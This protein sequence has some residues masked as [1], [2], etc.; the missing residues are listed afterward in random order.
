MYPIC[1][2]PQSK[3]SLA[4][5]PEHVVINLDKTVI[6]INE[7]SNLREHL[8]ILYGPQK[9]EVVLDRLIQIIQRFVADNPSFNRAND[10]K[11]E[12][13]TRVTEKDAILIA[14]G[15]IVQD[16]D[17]HGFT[18]LYHFLAGQVADAISTVHLLPFFPYSSD[19]GFSVIDYRAVD[20]QLGDWNEVFRIGLDYRLM[21]DA[22]INHISAE[23]SWFQSFLDDQPPFDKYFLIVPDGIDL[24]E[25]FRP[26]A[27]PLLTEFNTDTGPKNVWTTFSTDQVDLNFG[28]PDV[29]LEIIAVLLDYVSKGAEFIR[30]D[31]IA[32]LWKEPGTRSIHLPQTHRVVQLFRSVIDRVAPKVSLITETNV[33]HLDNISYFGNGFN[34][35]QL[36]Y[37]FSL[38]P[39]LLN[40]FHSGSATTLSEWAATLTTPSEQT[41]FFNFTASHDGI[42]IL[43]AREILQS[44]EIEELASHIESLGGLVSYKNNPD[45]TRSPYELNVNFLDALAPAMHAVENNELI[46]K[47]FLASQAIMLALK[48]VPGIYFHSLVGSRGWSEGVVARGMPRAINRE[49]LNRKKLEEELRNS[50]SLR[51]LVFKGYI[52]MLRCRSAIPAF[53]PTADQRVLSLDQSLFTIIRSRRENKSV[54]LCLHNVSP[55]EKH[56]SID[57]TALGLEPKSR[58]RDI[59][60]GEVFQGDGKGILRLVF[61]PYDYFWLVAV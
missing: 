3:G 42:G 12:I 10:D 53:H 54:I 5:T 29:L 7:S 60:S 24:S 11:D 1:W 4:A 32:Y 23:S 46:S 37:N 27:L 56:V 38:P 22:V 49:K 52:H 36:V 17:T 35:A 58:Y 41:T 44:D 13:K 25:V 2:N 57:L 40:A 43:P 19:D 61:H 14:Y 51:S 39:L 16:P 28:N 31:A 6:V 48:G 30:L 47:R 34:E 59:V 55:A 21:F 45:G 8:E 9:G 15:D 20:P 26:R 33:P 50:S 18:S